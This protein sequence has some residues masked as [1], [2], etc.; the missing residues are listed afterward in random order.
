[1]IVLRLSLRVECIVDAWV[2]NGTAI[3]APSREARPLAPIVLGRS[4]SDPDMGD[5]IATGLGASMVDFPE[6]LR[7]IFPDP[8]RCNPLSVEREMFGGRENVTPLVRDEF[9]ESVRLNDGADSEEPALDTVAGV[10]AVVVF[11]GLIIGV[12]DEVSAR[13]VIME[14]VDTFRRTLSSDADVDP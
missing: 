5:F 13:T 10:T 8:L 3:R 4:V 1:M 14:L 6:T 2:P 11:G 7:T 12:K 9:P